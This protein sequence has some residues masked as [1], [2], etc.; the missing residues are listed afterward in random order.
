[1]MARSFFGGVHPDDKKSLSCD[2]AIERFE[3]PAQVIIPWW[4]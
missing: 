2:K 4:R 1:M 3:G